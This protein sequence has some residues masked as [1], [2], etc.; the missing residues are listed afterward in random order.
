MPAGEECIPDLGWI[1][2]PDTSMSSTTAGG[3][4]V[5]RFVRTMWRDGNFPR[6][7]SIELSQRYVLTVSAQ[8]LCLSS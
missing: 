3:K 7:N 2:L 4:S 8:P 6:F 1:L 5:S